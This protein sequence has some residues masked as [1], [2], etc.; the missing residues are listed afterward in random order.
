[1]G[2]KSFK[3]LTTLRAGGPI[4]F[5][6]EVENDSEIREAVEFS[7]SKNSPL[8][9][10][11]E[12]SDILVSDKPFK[13]TVIKFVGKGFSLEEKDGKFFATAKAGEYWDDFVNYCVQNDLQGTECLSGIPGTVGAAPIQ[14]IGAYGQELKD[15]FHSL[16]AFDIEKKEVRKFNKEECQ[17]SYRESFFKKRENWQKFIIIDITL[18]LQKNASPEVKYDSLKNYL[19]ER[20][21]ENPTLKEVRDSVLEIRKG[22]FENYK[23]TPNA[24]SFFKNPQ[25]NEKDYR[26]LVEKYGEV[27][28]YQNSDG[29]F[30]CFAGWFIEKSG[31]KGKKYKNA[32]VS[33]KHALV[34][35]NP[36][37]KANSGEIFS[38]S[39]KIIK[40]VREK[41]GVTLEKEVQFINF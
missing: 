28:C 16:T 33:P 5:Y 34:L 3:Q 38:L 29:T 35:I 40:D 22:K 31:W 11:G 21:V 27:P 4:D 36:E 41:F 12:G 15:H 2:K 39:E 20:G 18:K 37:G 25:L 14:N 32:G 26:A 30:K 24:G 9:I 13:G 7:E 8:F 19:N 23:K 1:M 17:F 6:K 10:L